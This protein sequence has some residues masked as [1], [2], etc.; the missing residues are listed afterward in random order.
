M[1]IAG[2]L[3]QSKLKIKIP[4]ARKA[5]DFPYSLSLSHLNMPDDSFKEFVL[6]S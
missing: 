1:Q 2:L 4:V 5:M 6:T 3:V